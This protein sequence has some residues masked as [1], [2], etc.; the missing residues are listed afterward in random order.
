[1]KRYWLSIVT[2]S[3]VGLFVACGEKSAETGTEEIKA[4]ETENMEVEENEIHPTEDTEGVVAV[5]EAEEVEPGSK[6]RRK[7]LHNTSN[8]FPIIIR[9]FLCIL[10]VRHFLT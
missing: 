4:K 9:S 2:L 1:M 3:V 8:S 10:T 5:E 6:S 7:K